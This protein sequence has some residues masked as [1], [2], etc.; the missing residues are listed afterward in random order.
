M[1]LAIVKNVTRTCIF[2][3]CLRVFV[4]VQVQASIR[5]R[6]IKHKNLK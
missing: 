4:L 1:L 3:Q 5:I 2:T 6:N